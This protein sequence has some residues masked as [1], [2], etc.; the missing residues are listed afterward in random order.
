MRTLGLRLIVRYRKKVY[1][2]FLSRP[3]GISS[4]VS[5]GWAAERQT[6]SREGRKIWTAAAADHSWAQH[7]DL[8]RATGQASEEVRRR[9]RR[10]CARR[11]EHH[12]VM[13]KQS[14][15]TK[16][17]VGKPEANN[18]FPPRSLAWG[19]ACCS[20]V[21]P[22]R[23]EVQDFFDIS[24]QQRVDRGT[25][26]ALFHTRSEHPSSKCSHGGGICRAP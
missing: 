2:N 12:C 26:F 1:A 23:E 13:G 5:R 19:T 16:P 17:T 20:H 21:H 10:T 11:R 22:R 4:L 3:K 6:T 9:R 14:W 25:C 24:L 18:R 15:S 8:T 7:A